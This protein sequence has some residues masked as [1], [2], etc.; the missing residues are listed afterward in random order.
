MFS[1]N[2]GEINDMRRK[3]D[4]FVVKDPNNAGSLEPGT[5]QTEVTQIVQVWSLGVTNTL[6]I[7]RE[8]NYSHFYGQLIAK[9]AACLK[10]RDII[11]EVS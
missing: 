6:T 11:L 9:A 10:G 2:T 4:V 5:V 7:L 3:P 8:G 1:L